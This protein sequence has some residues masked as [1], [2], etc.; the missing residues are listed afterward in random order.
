ME[1]G[2]GLVHTAPAHGM[3]DYIVGKEYG[4][5][6]ECEV[7][8]NGLFTK[9][10]G[11][12]LEGK[13]VLGEGNAAVIS[14]L[15]R[16]GTLLNVSDYTH[17]YPHDWRT[18]RPVILRS[19]LQWFANL[20]S[21]K[22]LA[23]RC[24]DGVKMTPSHSLRRMVSML[25]G[26]DDWCISRQRVWGVPIPVFYKRGSEEILMNRASVN[27]VI[28]LVEKYGTD[29]WWEMATTDLL[30]SKVVDQ[31]GSEE[32]VKGEDTMD[33]WFDSGTS[34]ESVLRDKDGQDGVADLYLEGSD[35]HR[36]WFQSS[37]LTSVAVRGHAPYKHVITHGFVL[38]EQ[39]KKMSKSL[40]NIMSPNDVVS[41]NKKQPGYGADVMRLWAASTDYSS[42]VSLGQGILSRV[43]D[44]FKKVTKT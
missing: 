17:R 39:G 11:S 44:Q 7:D 25:E 20:S 28:R 35:Q 26:R 38:D 9:S 14:L 6:L 37:L 15:E 42:D 3:E 27:H 19:T 40:G 5:D 23:V 32:F 22:E 34:W 12:T 41:G 1:S 31:L 21:L 13:S 10:V 29:C 24:L 43:G 8:D 30:P 33:V 16:Q 18:K 36:G 2:T 4:L